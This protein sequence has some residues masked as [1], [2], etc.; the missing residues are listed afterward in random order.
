MF[1]SH[2]IY[3]RSRVSYATDLA[4]DRF[5]IQNVAN[6]ADETVSG[7]S[8]L[9][10]RFNTTY[11]AKLPYLIY[12]CVLGILFVVAIFGMIN[13][14]AISMKVKQDTHGSLRGSNTTTD[15]G[16]AH[17]SAHNK[18]HSSSNSFWFSMIVSLMTWLAL[19]QVNNVVG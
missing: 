11:G 2:L 16:T 14:T 7:Q 13:E 8:N 18:V 5:G 19:I 3:I 15:A 17:G 9:Y 4:L 6:E 1:S 12:A 10:R